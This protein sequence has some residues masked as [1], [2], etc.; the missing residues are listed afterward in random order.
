V[1]PQ[2]SIYFKIFRLTPPKLDLIVDIQKKMTVSKKFYFK[3]VKRVSLSSLFVV[4]GLIEGVHAQKAGP[5]EAK[6]LSDLEFSVRK[7]LLHSDPFLPKSQPEG[8]LNSPERIGFFVYDNESSPSNNEQRL[9]QN[10]FSEF[11]DDENRTI[12]LDLGVSSAQLRAHKVVEYFNKRNRDIRFSGVDFADITTFGNIN[13]SDE[14]DFNDFVARDIVRAAESSLVFMV[15]REAKRFQDLL[16]TPVK[17]SL[18][19]FKTQFWIEINPPSSLRRSDDSLSARE[20]QV[21]LD[22]NQNREPSLTEVE[23][24]Q[25][26]KSLVEA[27]PGAE[28]RSF[29][30]EDIIPGDFSV[31]GKFRTSV[32][33]AGLDWKPFP[34]VIPLKV[35]LSRLYDYEGEVQNFE[36]S[37]TCDLLGY[38]KAFIP[39]ENHIHLTARHNFETDEGFLELYF[40]R[41]F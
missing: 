31:Y 36:V 39:P 21:F 26:F 27:L 41:T 37:L 6:A 17:E 13:P 20:S 38:Y 33:G 24:S 2:K 29:F 22:S 16:P 11:L 19:Y 8:S 4:F 14:E 30:L 35:R 7:G 23:N 3:R 10:Y 9:D 5:L 18:R 12:G 25:E 28:A 34:E 1:W 15:D 32:F 40:C